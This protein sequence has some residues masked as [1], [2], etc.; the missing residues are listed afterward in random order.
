VKFS[1]M[2]RYALWGTVALTAA[3]NRREYRMATTWFPHF[4]ANTI[5]LLL[6]D[7]YRV[8]FPKPHEL[9]NN[10][11]QA[12][13][14]IQQV[15]DAAIRD[16]PSYAIYVAPLA[17]GYILSH[18]KFNIYKGRLA[19]LRL[20]GF[21]LDAIPHTATA[22]ALTALID[23]TLEIASKKI[24]ADEQAKKLA[25]IGKQNSALVSG[26]TLA[27]VTAIWEYGEYLI[28]RHELDLRGDI[29]RINM[30]WGAQDTVNDIFSNIAGWALAVLVKYQIQ[31]KR[32]PIFT[33][34]PFNPIYGQAKRLGLLAATTPAQNSQDEE[35]QVHEV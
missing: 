9:P 23:D 2:M 30:Q 16:N 24:E 22:F 34:P 17:L 25:E 14:E 4:F 3:A 27:L 11:N 32:R 6:P 35:E 33:D 15:I 29:T 10:E 19:E 12:L 18:P 21:G 26:V 28:H 13:N 1:D 7:V 5:S 8:L 20:A 31:Q